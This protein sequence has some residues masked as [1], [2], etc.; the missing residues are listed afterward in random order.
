M[1][2]AIPLITPSPVDQEEF[3]E[4]TKLADGIVRSADRLQAFFSADSHT[5]VGRLDHRDVIGS[6]PDG[7]RNIWKIMIQIGLQNHG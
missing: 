3:L 7:Q 2:L 6:V 5:H 4:E 1:S